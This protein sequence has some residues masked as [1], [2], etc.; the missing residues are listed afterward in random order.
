MNDAHV[1]GHH[2][3]PAHAHV[4]VLPRPGADE[5]IVFI[6][7]KTAQRHPAGQRDV[8]PQHRVVPDVHFGHEEA[9]RPD[10]RR[11]SLAVPA[12]YRGVGEENATVADFDEAFLRHR[13]AHHGRV[14]QH[15]AAVD[16]AVAPDAHAT[17]RH[18]V[19]V[20]PRAGADFDSF[21]DHAIGTDDGGRVH[22]RAAVHDGAGMD[23]FGRGHT[24]LPSFV[25]AGLSASGQAYVILP[26]ERKLPRKTAAG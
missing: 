7:R 25:A 22:A 14:A 18:Y 23:S 1:A 8:L 15:Y 4:L 5:G 21:F 16:V 20:Q 12:L 3:Q 2:R 17:V 6:H 13:A 26:S 9:V 11:C 19:R 10:A 24:V